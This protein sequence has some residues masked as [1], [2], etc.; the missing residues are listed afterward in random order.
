MGARTAATR[1]KRRDGSQCEEREGPENHAEKF[2]VNFNFSGTKSETHR[3]QL[4]SGQ[5]EKALTRL[6]SQP[7][8]SKLD[9]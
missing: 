4:P 6:I 5:T 9:S 1:K 7:T 2:E 8:P 3:Q